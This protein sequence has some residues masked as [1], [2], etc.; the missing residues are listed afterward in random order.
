RLARMAAGGGPV[1]A[2]K[3]R[4]LRT[5]EP[6]PALARQYDESHRR[7]QALYGLLR[8]VPAPRAEPALA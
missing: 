6:R 1:S 3:P 7:W 8:Q 5:F 2:T 4:R